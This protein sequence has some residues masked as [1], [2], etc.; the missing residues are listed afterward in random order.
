M[1]IETAQNW[2][3]TGAVVLVGFGLLGPIGALPATS[4]IT[5]FFADLAFFPLDGSP[6]QLDP[7]ARFFWAITGGVIAGWGVMIWITAT[8]LLPRDPALA[9]SMILTAAVVWFVIDSLGSALAGA[10]MNALYN[11]G[12]L[13]LFVVPL[14]RPVE[15]AANSA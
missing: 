14:W 9:R 5:R 10:P 13:V 1:H 4:E 12:F 8:R 2:L 6:A 7:A 15:A 3:K 11:V